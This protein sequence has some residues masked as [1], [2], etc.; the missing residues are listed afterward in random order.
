MGKRAQGMIVLVWL[1]GLLAQATSAAEPTDLLVLYRRWAKDAVPKRI[2]FLRD[3]IADARKNKDISPRERVKIIRE[4][5][6]ELSGLRAATF[7]PPL[8][9]RPFKIGNVGTLGLE[10]GFVVSV[11]DTHEMV[12]TLPYKKVDPNA[13]PNRKVPLIVDDLVQ[14]ILEGIPTADLGNADPIELPLVLTVIGKNRAH[15]NL[16]ILRVFDGSE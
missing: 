6:A 8:L 7:N 12:V 15:G 14:V 3:S 4:A 9:A 2:E 11:I 16:A 1:A 10:R 13:P 5:E